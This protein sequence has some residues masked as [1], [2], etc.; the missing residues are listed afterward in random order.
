MHQMSTPGPL[1]QVEAKRD[2]H[3]FST[4]LAGTLDRGLLGDELFLLP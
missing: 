2:Q 1:E 4:H 3:S